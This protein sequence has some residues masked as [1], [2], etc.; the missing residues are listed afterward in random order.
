MSYPRQLPFLLAAC[1]LLACSAS[2]DTGVTG[3]D[4]DSASGDGD[5]STGDGDDHGDG[6][7]SNGDGDD[8]HG[9]GDDPHGDGDSDGPGDGD[10]DGDAGD[11]DGN[12]DG[13]D[14]PDGSMPDHP[15][16]PGPDD[17]AD[18]P[19]QSAK[20][21]GVWNQPFD[22]RMTDYPVTWAISVVHASMLYRAI[23]INYTPNSVLSIAIKES[24]LSCRNENPQNAQ[25]QMAVKDGCFQI[26]G[27]SAYKTL[28]QLF[29]ERFKATHA[30]LISGT[31]FESA[32]L[33][34]VYYAL[35]SLARFRDYRSDPGDPQVFFDQHPDPQAA[36]KVL[37]GAYNRGL[38]WEQLD[39]IFRDCRKTE[40]T[41]CFGGHA[42]A[43]DHA[44]KIAEYTRALDDTTPFDTAL[45]AD[46]LF[47]Y[48]KSIAKLYPEVSDATAK[49][50]LM[51]AFDQ[52]RGSESTIS[53]HKR[54]RQ[55]L[56][57]LIS[58]LPKIPSQDQAAKALCG[59][60]QLSHCD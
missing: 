45:T 24:A 50:A 20:L 52:Y 23:G 48:W 40:V 13:P 37:C 5:D 14:D 46:D 51:D 55:V 9:D 11:G 8:S 28:E 2:N 36:Q 7:D 34:T 49:K 16:E 10:G 6:D 22:F 27:E 33:S 18:G 35:F 47:A 42:I 4:H 21:E 53:F 38:W 60:S 56:A 54:I 25:E 59:L 1:V 39:D 17:P 3:E 43:I 15:S 30:D 44:T 26:E 12:G 58:V 32:A 57:A 19:G 31:H 29:P 41:E